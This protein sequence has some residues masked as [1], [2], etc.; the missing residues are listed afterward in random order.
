MN[1]FH[2]QLLGPGGLLDVVTQEMTMEARPL[3]LKKESHR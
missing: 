1:T 3:S 2:P